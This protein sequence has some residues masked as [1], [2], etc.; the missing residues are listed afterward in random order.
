MATKTA[1]SDPSSYTA[2]ET[3]LLLFDCMNFHVSMIQDTEKKQQFI[4]PI[5]TLLATARKNRVAIIHCH[6]DVK[7]ELTDFNKIKEKW[8]T[9]YRPMLEV[10]PELAAECSDFTPPKDIESDRLEISTKISVGYRSTLLNKGL[11]RLLKEELHAKHLILAGF[12]TSGPIV[13][14][15][16]MAL[17]LILF[18][19]WL[20]MLLGT[21]EHLHRIIIDSIISLLVWV[22]TTE[23]AT[24]NMSNH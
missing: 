2:S 7:G 18:S 15:L 13:G 3:A 11:Q 6:V 22:A 24:G 14:T 1:P 12:I 10:T 9:I 4:E 21:D 5:N 8:M 17:T 19:L 20:K 16:C 23:Q